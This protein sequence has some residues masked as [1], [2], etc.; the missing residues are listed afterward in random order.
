MDRGLHD[1]KSVM[2]NFLDTRGISPMSLKMVSLNLIAGLLLV[3]LATSAFQVPA[4]SQEAEEAPAAQSTSEREGRARANPRGRLPNFYTRVVTPQQ[5]EQIYEIQQ[6]YSEE[7]EALRAQLAA[8]QTKMNKEIEG[9]LDAE[10]LEQV[11]TLQEEAQ[12][13]RQRRARQRAAAS[14]T[15]SAED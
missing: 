6:G 12:Q 8:V 4:W 11:K 14:E 2:F 10:Q 13:R 15:T 5:R 9:V 1:R 7:I 3:G